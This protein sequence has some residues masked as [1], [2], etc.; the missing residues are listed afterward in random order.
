MNLI[1][2]EVSQLQQPCFEGLQR[3]DLAVLDH[4]SNLYDFEQL[5]PAAV[6]QAERFLI[7]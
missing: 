4:G 5:A 3:F 1:V 6:T 2:T 7:V